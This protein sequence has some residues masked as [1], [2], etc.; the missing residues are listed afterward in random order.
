MKLTGVHYI[1]PPSIIDLVKTLYKHKLFV[2]FLFIIY[3]M[4]RMVAL[5]YL[6]KHKKFIQQFAIY[7]C[8]PITR[9]MKDSTVSFFNAPHDISNLHNSRLSIYAADR[10]PHQSAMLLLHIGCRNSRIIMCVFIFLFR[11][12][13]SII[14]LLKIFEYYLM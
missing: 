10:K 5:A 2:F 9:L 8:I 12:A 1:W 14:F 6:T 4:R 13:D 11:R 7:A 3:K